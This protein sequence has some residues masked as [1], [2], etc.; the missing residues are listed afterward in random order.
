M[1]NFFK[2]IFRRGVYSAFRIEEGCFG[3]ENLIWLGVYDNLEE[4]KALCTN[5]QRLFLFPNESSIIHDCSKDYPYWAIMESEINQ[6][7]EAVR[8][9]RS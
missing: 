4:A 6:S 2:F 3:G 1:F 5:Q 8:V 7:E 9:W